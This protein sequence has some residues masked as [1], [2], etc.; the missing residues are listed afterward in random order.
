MLQYMEK[1]SI[2]LKPEQH[3]ALTEMARREGQDIDDLITQ[4]LQ[5]GIEKRQR[6]THP[7]T[8]DERLQALEQI[9]EHREAFLAKRNNT[10]LQIDP[11]SLLNHI[12]E[13]CD[14]HLFSL[15]QIPSDD[16][17]NIPFILRHLQIFVVKEYFF[18]VITP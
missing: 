15:S 9:E 11:V 7:M 8:A 10:P 3:E 17:A 4:I 6:D 18:A 16:M 12:R 1:T 13:E 14:Q 2:S 5:E